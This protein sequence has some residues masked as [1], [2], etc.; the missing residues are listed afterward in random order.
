MSARMYKGT[1]VRVHACSRVR[2]YSYVLLARLL[3]DEG[4]KRRYERDL[5]SKF[6]FAPWQ[7]EEDDDFNDDDEEDGSDGANDDNDDGRKDEW[8]A[9]EKSLSF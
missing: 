4:G 5:D 7:E 2:M 8:V 9:R 3:V 6:R 1:Y